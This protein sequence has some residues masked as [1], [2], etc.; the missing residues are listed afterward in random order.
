M[1]TRRHMGFVAAGA[2]LLA[3]T[4]LS[5][6]FQSWTWM[7]Q[8]AFAVGIIAA[9]AT[10]IRALR[11]RIAA[12]GLGMMGA[13][14]L[15]LT[16]LFSD[17]HA[18]LGIIPTPE[19]FS[20]FADLLSRSGE[21]IRSNGV[22][23]PDLDGLLFLT[24]FGI[25]LVAILTDLVTVGMRRPALAGLPM[26]GIYAVPVA[27]YPDSVSVVPFVFAAAAYLWLLVSD[28]VDRVRRFGRRFTG[29]GRDV[30][31]WEPS[32][33]AAAGRRLAVLGVLLAIV[34]PLAIPQVSTSFFDQFGAEGSGGTGGK[35]N[36]RGGPG[37]VDLF[38]DLAGR[39]NHTTITDLVKVT[40][41]DAN[42]YYL[43]FGVA[44]E[45][46]ANGFRTRT[47]SGQAIGNQLPDPNQR[48]SFGVVREKYAA[49]VEVSKNF[50]MPML[51]V[52]AEPV[53]T[54]RIGSDW[55][56]DANMQIV[57]SLRSR[58]GGRGYEFEYVRSTYTPQELNSSPELS[59]D[60][61]I[62]RQFTSVPLVAEVRSEVERLTKNATTPYEKVRAIYDFFSSK[63]GFRYDLSTQRGTSGQKIVDFIKNK[64]G[65][66][67]QYA[68][69]M[70]WLVR[71]AGIP[72]RVAFGFTRGSS[73]S[74]ADGR[75]TF[76]LTNR[77][78]HAWTE[79]YFEG[80]GWVPFD[81]TPSSFVAGSV[82]SAWAPDPNQV[83]GPT[84]GPSVSPGAGGDPGDDIPGRD[85]GERDPDEALGPDGLPV[86]PAP[87]WPWWTLGGVIA[88]LLLLS[89]PMLR[90]RALRS[91]RSRPAGAPLGGEAVTGD[92][93]P[94][95]TMVVVEGD[96]ERARNLAHEAWDELI[97]TLIDFRVPADAAETPRA[98][99]RRLVAEQ[100]FG[101]EAATGAAE[102]G[103]AE[104]RARYARIPVDPQ[105]LSGSLRAVRRE[106]SAGADRRT[107]FL[108]AVMPPSVTARWKAAVL[109]GMSRAVR[110]A[111]DMRDWAM[112]FSP[113]RLLSSSR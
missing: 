63:N 103:T 55:S 84:S 41:N 24:V 80:F 75:Y 64:V 28:N 48:P 71:A 58:S 106:L 17:G 5:G 44:D 85:P 96:V 2:T 70:A 98:V 51:P 46:N 112:R 100:Q 22:P 73:Q 35:G 93:A 56:Y 60:N 16:L 9:T 59:V 23:V 87:T 15:V 82:A 72:S 90:R 12:Q 50:D 3:A 13:L 27:V 77:N 20:Y 86:A 6:I 8:S 81:A 30:D 95:G 45:L 10:G 1:T 33:L 4:P 78:L 19:T 43:R 101:R 53:T 67:E 110:K 105:P 14:L 54:R 76:T 97:D 94:P 52:Y 74:S 32:P 92:T 34:L 109:D 49:Q 42:P 88:I 61:A 21:Q 66:C 68:A 40:T 36:N 18:L 26:L 79:V 111:A 104:E 89:V 107:R 65:F 83:T 11:G 38:A 31:V 91:R 99:A 108:A 37:T 7:L 113:R 69:A 57:F 62:R 47:P 25:G 39:L 102:L 29:E